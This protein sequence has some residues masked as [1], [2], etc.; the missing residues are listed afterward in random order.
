MERSL[1]LGPWARR[2]CPVFAAAKIYT[3]ENRLTERSATW[4]PLFELE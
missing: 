3:L 4:V 1:A 2:G